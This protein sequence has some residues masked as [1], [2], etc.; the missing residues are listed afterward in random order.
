MEED[1]CNNES[2]KLIKKESQSGLT[3]IDTPQYEAELSKMVEQSLVTVYCEPEEA[4]SQEEDDEPGLISTTGR[5]THETVQCK[6]IFVL[7]YHSS[8]YS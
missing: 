7:E 5:F 1:T 2:Q 8:L 3:Q 6:Q 4:S